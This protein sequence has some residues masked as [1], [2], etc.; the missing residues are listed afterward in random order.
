ME[1]PRYPHAESVLRDLD[2]VSRIVAAAFSGELAAGSFVRDFCD[3]YGPSMTSEVLA[4]Q[5]GTV[6]ADEAHVDRAVL[7]L[8]SRLCDDDIAAV[9]D[10]PVFTRTSCF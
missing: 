3:R 6:V 1:L 8:L 10:H 5:I 7:V 4:D 2:D 9:L